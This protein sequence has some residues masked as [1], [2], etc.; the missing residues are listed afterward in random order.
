MDYNK[1]SNTVTSNIVCECCRRTYSLS[2]IE[3]EFCLR[4][5]MPIPKYCLECRIK[6]DEERTLKKEIVAKNV[7]NIKEYAKRL[8]EQ[9]GKRRPLNKIDF[10]FIFLGIFFAIL[11]YLI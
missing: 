1:V 4:G 10:I 3:R 7:K 5:K 6:T 11:Y 9:E 2:D 8:N